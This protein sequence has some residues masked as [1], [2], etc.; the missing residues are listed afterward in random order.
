MASIFG[1]RRVRIT[2]LNDV[3]KKLNREIKGI[4]KRSKAGLTSAGLLVKR[5]SIQKTPVDTGFLRSSAYM[6][7][8]ERSY[9]GP[10]VEI[11]YSASYALPVHEQNNN[12]IVGEWKFLETALRMSHRDIV[13]IIRKRAKVK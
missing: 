2:G 11:G 1:Q 5:R 9:G 12:Y 4:K 13:E 3:L 8:G 6:L 10:F 7:I